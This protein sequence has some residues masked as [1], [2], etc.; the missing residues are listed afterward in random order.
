MSDVGDL[1]DYINE[2]TKKELE[3]AKFT[4]PGSEEMKFE[5]DSK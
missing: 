3:E 2:Q 4:G 1:E 5:D